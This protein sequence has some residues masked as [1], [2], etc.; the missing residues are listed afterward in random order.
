MCSWQILLNNG[1]DVNAIASIN[2]ATPLHIAAENGF[3][4]IAKV[5][6]EQRVIYDCVVLRTWLRLELH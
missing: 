5:V 2:G 1:A 4:S 6:A 3:L